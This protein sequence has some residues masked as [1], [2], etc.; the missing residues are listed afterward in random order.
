MQKPDDVVP[1]E[2]ILK[3]TSVND[4]AEPYK[5]K[6]FIEGK[7]GPVVWTLKA[8]NEASYCYFEMV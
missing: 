7:K 8:H 4:P 3:V 5:F 6:V 2:N 1:L